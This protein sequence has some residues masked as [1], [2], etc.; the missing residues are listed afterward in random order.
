MGR[1]LNRRH[2]ATGE[3]LVDLRAKAIQLRAEG[4]SVRQIGK[5]LGVS[6]SC[7]HRWATE[8][9]EHEIVTARNGGGRV[10]PP[11]TRPLANKLRKA[12]FAREQRIAM[13]RE[14]A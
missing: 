2:P 7:A 10:Y 6:R 9:P 5:T 4:V 12:G 1:H 11:G 3:L 8:A 13:V 14:L